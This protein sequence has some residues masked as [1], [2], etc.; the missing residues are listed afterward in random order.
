M[1]KRKEGNMINL[2]IAV[3]I[4]LWA[5]S[6]YLNI[7]VLSNIFLIA[8]VGFFIVHIIQGAQKILGTR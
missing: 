7:S 2:I 8:A 4:F 5:M 6:I 3:L 1:F